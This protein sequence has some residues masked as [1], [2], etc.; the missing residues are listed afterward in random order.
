MIEALLEVGL[1]LILEAVVQ[2]FVELA[3]ELG[4][5]G[6][7]RGLRRKP[8]PVVAT[9]GWLLVGAG[10]GWLFAWLVPQRLFPRGP[11]HGASLVIGPL[12]VGLVM[13]LWG[14]YQRG[15]GRQTTQLAT[16]HGGAAFA[17]GSS[18]VRFLLVD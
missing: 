13:R 17:L 3:L 1:D 16:F 14:D 18:A 6:L 5:E 7:A 8:H 2:L 9:V 10:L 12:A 11:F 15:R 4:I